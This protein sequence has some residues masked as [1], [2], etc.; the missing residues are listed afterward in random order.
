MYLCPLAFINLNLLLSYIIIP[1]FKNK[2]KLKNTNRRLRQCLVFIKNILIIECYYCNYSLEPSRYCAEKMCFLF[3][4]LHK[5]LNLSKNELYLSAIQAPIMY[6]QNK[7]WL[8]E[9]YY[10]NL[11]IQNSNAFIV[12][13]V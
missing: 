8:L 11:E 3:S 13:Y 5:N 7:N 2:K 12:Y 10:L 6:T 9:T 4:L 1:M